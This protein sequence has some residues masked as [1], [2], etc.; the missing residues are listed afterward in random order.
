M[1]RC[2][3]III[4][5]G[6][7]QKARATSE[8]IARLRMLLLSPDNSGE[9]LKSALTL[10]ASH[11]RRIFVSAFDALVQVAYHQERNAS[12]IKKFFFK[13]ALKSFYI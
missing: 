10:T 13:Y 11:R 12:L 4:T 1:H 3:D 6:R 9:R 8:T 7:A 5:A 2:D